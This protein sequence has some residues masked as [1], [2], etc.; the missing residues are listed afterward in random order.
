MSVRLT[1]E[2]TADLER[3]SKLT[4]LRKHTLAQLAI[5]AA[6]RAAKENDWKL[7][8]PMEMNSG[9]HPGKPA[10]KRKDPA[11]GTEPPR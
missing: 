6:L 7:N 3:I 2:Q 5:D 4:G 8:L 10:R 1:A 11:G 9:K